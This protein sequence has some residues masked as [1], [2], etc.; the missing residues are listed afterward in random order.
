MLLGPERVLELISSSH[1]VTIVAMNYSKGKVFQ[2]QGL[3]LL[4]LLGRSSVELRL[5]KGV[6]FGVWLCFWVMLP[7]LINGVQLSL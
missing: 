4:R 2:L 3:P 5:G 1:V 7:S 6:R